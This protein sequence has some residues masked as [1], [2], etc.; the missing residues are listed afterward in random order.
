ML[1]RLFATLLLI[2]HQ[3][4][5][6]SRCENGQKSAAPVRSLQGRNEIQGVDENHCAEGKRIAKRSPAVRRRPKPK[7]TNP[8]KIQ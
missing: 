3:R 6:V 5:P 2:V 7:P 8:K 4:E 1:W